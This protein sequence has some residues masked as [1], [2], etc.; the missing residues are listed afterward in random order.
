MD[1][2]TVGDT[3]FHNTILFLVFNFSLL[4]NFFQEYY[5]YQT[6]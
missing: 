4:K 3:V 1:K 5:E 2:F 6:V